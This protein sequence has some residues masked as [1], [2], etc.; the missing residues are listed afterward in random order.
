MRVGLF[1]SNPQE[2]FSLT[3][4]CVQFIIGNKISRHKPLSMNIHSAVNTPVNNSR[5]ET[6][7]NHVS[8]HNKHSMPQNR[9]HVQSSANCHFPCFSQLTI[10]FINEDLTRLFLKTELYGEIR[11]FR[12]TSPILLCINALRKTSLQK[13][14]DRLMKEPISAYERGSFAPR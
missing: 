11:E 10:T 5:T 6:P 8:S 2:G 14:Y 7:H 1:L 12:G 9:Q 13:R 4:L 3:Q